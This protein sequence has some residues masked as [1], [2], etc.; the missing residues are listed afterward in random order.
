MSHIYVKPFSL[1]SENEC[2]ACAVMQWILREAVQGFR[3]LKI[4]YPC[5]SLHK[6]AHSSH[7]PEIS[8][9]LGYVRHL[10][11]RDDVLRI[12]SFVEQN[13]TN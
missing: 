4:V 7:L 5:F 3:I 6:L 12:C 10:T 2:L 1:A 13:L 11:V 8:Q 9:S